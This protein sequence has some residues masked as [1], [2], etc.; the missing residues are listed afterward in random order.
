M[1][2]KVSTSTIIFMLSIGLIWEFYEFFGDTFFGTNMQPNLEDTIYDMIF[3]VF[4]TLIIIVIAKVF[5]SPGS[6]GD[7]SGG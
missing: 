4:G 5:W 6:R 1:V 2:Q 7:P 3:N